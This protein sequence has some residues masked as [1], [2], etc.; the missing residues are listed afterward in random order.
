MVHVQQS[1]KKSHLQTSI[2]KLQSLSSLNY[3]W[4]EKLKFVEL[5][6]NYIWLWEK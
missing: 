2:R 1:Y 3:F 4:H 6:V 5:T